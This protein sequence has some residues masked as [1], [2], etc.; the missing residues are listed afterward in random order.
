MRKNSQRRIRQAWMR[1][2]RRANE[3]HGY[4][5]ERSSPT[6]SGGGEFGPVV[7]H[8]GKLYILKNDG[9]HLVERKDEKTGRNIITI[10]R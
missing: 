10:E 3:G 2:F 7:T 1:K 9:R 6:Q 4:K 8:P 5:F